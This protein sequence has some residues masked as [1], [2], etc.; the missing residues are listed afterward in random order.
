[1]VQY[2]VGVGGGIDRLHA[3]VVSP[4][5]DGLK[6]VAQDRRM[7]QVKKGDGTHHVGRLEAVIRSAME[8]GKLSESDIAGIGISS[9][10]QIDY[11]RCEI[12]YSTNLDLRNF[13]LGAALS[14][15]FSGVPV[16]LI[17]DVVG[18]MLGEHRLGI[19]KGVSHLV[20]I[21]VA[22]GT[23]SAM[24]LNN[25]LYR[26]A[27]DLAGEIGHTSV[28]LHGRLCDCGNSGCLEAICSQWAI[29]RAIKARWHH[30][31]P[32]TLAEQVDLTL[33][34]DSVTHVITPHLIAEAIR[35]KD[36]T[37]IRVIEEAA[38]GMGSSIACVI[39]MLNPQMIVLGGG[40]MEAVDLLFD[41]SREIALNWALRPSAETVSIVRT[42]LGSIAEVYGAAVSA[43]E[44]VKRRED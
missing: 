31:W 34:L 16:T 4:E 19:A 2:F 28:N 18:H 32:T 13:P 24:L 15:R 40:M 9:P 12:I 6:V 30:G 37:V 11:D 22:Y 25:D 29:A 3:M 17:N 26:G 10:G 27:S 42:K 20:Y 23:G 35:N 39:N 1:M 36:K 44:L 8:K 33:D 41:R 5:Q 38:E 21:Y 14:K 7:G 43:I